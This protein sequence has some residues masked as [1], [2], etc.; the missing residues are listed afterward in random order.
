M[1]VIALQ[2]WLCWRTDAAVPGHAPK[3]TLVSGNSTTW[4]ASLC[5]FPNNEWLV[6]TPWDN[7]FLVSASDRFDPAAGVT[8]FMVSRAC[9]TGSCVCVHYTAGNR[10]QFSVNVLCVVQ[11]IMTGILLCPMQFLGLRS[12][13]HPALVPRMQGQNLLL[14][15]A[16][17]KIFLRSYPLN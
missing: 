7:C 8:N 15:T 13:T 4:G 2:V 11:L 3:P 14:M 9:F 16:T 17:K 6:I 5:A 1:H 10:V 12:W